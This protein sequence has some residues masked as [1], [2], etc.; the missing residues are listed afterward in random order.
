MDPTPG[1]KPY[2]CLAM[3]PGARAPVP[4]A[5]SQA[6]GNYM[7]LHNSSILLQPY[8]VRYAY[9]WMSSWASLVPASA[10]SLSWPTHGPAMR[11]GSSQVECGT[12]RYMV[13]QDGTVR[14]DLIRCNTGAATTRMAGTYTCSSSSRVGLCHTGRSQMRC[15]TG[16]C[17]WQY[18]MAIQRT[19]P[20]VEEAHR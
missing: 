15:G 19:G 5:A 3:L 18:D 7:L 13:V 14:C 2:R 17:T 4:L 11:T 9:R 20:P 16:R 8:L 1:N 10:T 6:N 12:V